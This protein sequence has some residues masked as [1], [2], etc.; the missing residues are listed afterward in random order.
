MARRAVCATCLLVVLCLV[1]VAFHAGVLRTTPAAPGGGA[2]ELRPRAL[3]AEHAPSDAG[4]GRW[5][6]ATTIVCSSAGPTATYV[7]ENLG[8]NT[9][10][11]TAYAGTGGGI[12][13]VCPAISPGTTASLVVDADVQYVHWE[14]CIEN[15]VAPVCWTDAY[16]VD[17]YYS[18]SGNSWVPELATVATDKAFCLQELPEHCPASFIC[19]PLTS[20]ALAT[21]S[22]FFCTGAC[23]GLSADVRLR[24]HC[25]LPWRRWRVTLQ[26]PWQLL[27]Y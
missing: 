2:R 25:R 11:I 18:A 3:H 24:A 19:E 27:C 7:F 8:M 21:A 12:K 15:S 26:W 23:G 14:L 1:C 6:T 10:H 22:S 13:T 20:S 9:V 16:A 17:S 4:G 5:F